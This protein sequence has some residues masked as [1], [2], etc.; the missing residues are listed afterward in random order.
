MHKYI[1]THTHIHTYIHTYIHMMQASES[2]LQHPL[3]VAEVYKKKAKKRSNTPPTN[4]NGQISHTS[5]HSKKTQAAGKRYVCMYVCMYVYIYKGHA[6]CMY[7]FTEE[8]VKHVCMYLYIRR[9]K[10]CIHIYIYI[11]ICIHIYIYIYTYRKIYICIVY[12]SKR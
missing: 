6:L 7:T 8:N 10:L 1:H 9:Q 5:K 2:H 12:K 4:C 11:Y 3:P